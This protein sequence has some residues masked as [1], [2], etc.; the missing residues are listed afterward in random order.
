[1]LACVFLSAASQK[2][3]LKDEFEMFLELQKRLDATKPGYNPTAI[4]VLESKWQAA[5][6]D[7]GN[8]Q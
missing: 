2:P 5:H 7:L 6:K 1:M 3:R 4:N 8:L